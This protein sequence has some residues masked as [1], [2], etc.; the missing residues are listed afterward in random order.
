MSAQHASRG[1]EMKQQQLGLRLSQL[2]VA[3]CVGIWLCR[4]PI[5]WRVHSLP[6]LLQHLT[7]VQEATAMSS[8]ME[9]DQGVRIVRRICQLRSF[10]DSCSGRPISRKPWR[11]I[12]S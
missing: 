5:R 12:T 10:A 3:L 8:P 9:M 7:P 1:G 4:L 11:S 2:W 6:R